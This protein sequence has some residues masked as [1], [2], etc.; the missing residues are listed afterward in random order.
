[1]DDSY[2]ASGS[3]ASVSS[4][5]AARQMEQVAEAFSGDAD[6]F[7]SADSGDIADAVRTVATAIRVVSERYR[8]SD[9]RPMGDLELVLDFHKVTIALSEVPIV[10]P[11][12]RT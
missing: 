6:R 8:G 9:Q 11:S 10:C 4:A 3:A 7:D 2:E 5:I 1:M 12:P